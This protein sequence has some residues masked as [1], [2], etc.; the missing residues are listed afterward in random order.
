MGGFRDLL[1]HIVITVLLPTSN[2]NLSNTYFPR[3]TIESGPEIKVEIPL[4]GLRPN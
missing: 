3:A 2:I 4:M 1:V